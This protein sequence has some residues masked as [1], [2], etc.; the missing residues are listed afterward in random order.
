MKLG[1]KIRKFR[2]ITAMT[3]QEFAD[4]G[5]ITRAA[6]QAIE[7]GRNQNPRMTT[8]IGIAKAMNISLDRLVRE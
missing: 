8:L 7:N 1:T 3:Q 5:E 6:V 2:T 4:K